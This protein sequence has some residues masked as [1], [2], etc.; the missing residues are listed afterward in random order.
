[1]TVVGAFAFPDFRFQPFNA[2]GLAISMAGAIYYATKSAMRVWPACTA[3][4]QQQRNQGCSSPAA[5]CALQRE[6]CLKAS[7]PTSLEWTPELW[8]A[9]VATC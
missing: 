7:M 8:Y 6:P 3:L 5:T 1:M 2:V 4:A 9:C